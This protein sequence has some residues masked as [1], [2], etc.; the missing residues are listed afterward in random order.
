MRSDR[1]AAEC[2][3]REI[4]LHGSLYGLYTSY[5]PVGQC[6]SSAHFLGLLLDLYNV[7]FYLLAPYFAT[8]P[9][10][11]SC[12]S[13]HVYTRHSFA[14][15]C[16]HKFAYK[17]PSLCASTHMHAG[18]CVDW[19]RLKPSALLDA[20]EPK[21]VLAVANTCG[22]CCWKPWLTSRSARCMSLLTRA[23][24]TDTSLRDDDAK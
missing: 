15:H 4:H 5:V 19:N 22:G 1:G 2:A 8:R 9:V 11:M 17:L 16:S 23:S 24:H 12:S 14:W 3:V 20:G 7:N 18:D 21:P 10:H 6:T 13:V